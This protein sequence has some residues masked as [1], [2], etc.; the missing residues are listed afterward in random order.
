MMCECRVWPSGGQATACVM[1]EKMGKIY[2]VVKRLM[3]HDEK[4]AVAVILYRSNVF[5]S[6]WRFFSD[7]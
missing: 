3:N 4:Y 5:T 2:F 7:G 6:L 1:R